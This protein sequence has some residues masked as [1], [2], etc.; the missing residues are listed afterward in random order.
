VERRRIERALGIAAIATIAIVLPPL[1]HAQSAENVAVVINDNSPDSQRIGLAYAQ[2]R[3]IPDSNVLHIQTST[4]ETVDRS[5]FSATIEGP[6]GTAINRLGLQDRILYLVLTKGVPLR[7]S[8]T[9]GPSGTMASVDSELTLLYRRMTGQSVNAS[10]PVPNPYFLAETGI[11]DARPF[12][13]RLFDIF[14]VSRLDGFTA[15]EALSLIERAGTTGTKGRFVLDKRDTLANRTGESWLDLAARR[16]ADQGLADLVTLEATSKPARGFTD[17]L[18]YFSWGSTDPQNRVRR[19]G[20]TFSPGAIAASYVGSD[21]RT[22]REPPADWVPTGE[23]VSRAAVFA[24][25]SESLVGDLIRDGVTGAAGYVAQPLLNGTVRP[26]ILFPAY[27][28][29]FNLIEAFYLA[30]PSLSWQGV[31]IGDPLCAPFERRTLSRSEIED[32]V[33]P[34]TELPAL[35]SKHRLAVAAAQ[36]PGIPEKA[37]ALHVRADVLTGRDDRSGAREAVDGALGIAPRFV[38]ALLQRAA[39][40]EIAADRDAVIETYRQIIAIDPGHVIALNNL[41]Y[42]LAVH[43]QEPEEALGLAERAVSKAPNNAMI[44]ET[45]AWIRYLLKDHANAARL[46]QQV[47]RANV[48]DAEVRMHAAVVFAAVGSHGIAQQELAVAL[49]LSPALADRPEVKELQ[50]QLAK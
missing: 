43:R 41:A 9:T 33:D 14:L 4:E 25:S 12:T 27:V 38:A 50:A 23:P 20:M 16:I 29:G 49:K 5:T 8:G 31:V 26:Q 44:L 19:S 45:L 35:F 36:W 39:L 6:L 42:A 32:G 30:M 47:V 21:A 10:G 13:H 28:A 3:A 46:M 34:V 24:G 40:D 15:D 17:V 2:A 11:A 22:F 48:P 1:A 7:V 18:G 37:L